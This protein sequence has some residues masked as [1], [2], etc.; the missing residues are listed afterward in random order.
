MG[1]EAVATVMQ[2]WY[3]TP[4]T[5]APLAYWGKPGKLYAFRQTAAFAKT[6]AVHAL[7]GAGMGNFS[8]K[9]ATKATGLG[10]EGHFPD[11]KIYVSKNYMQAH[12]FT[13]LYYFAQP[14]EA[15]SMMNMPNSV[16]NQLA[17]EYGITGLLLFAFLY[18]GFFIRH[19]RSIKA[20]RYMLLAVLLFF[21]YEY[22]FE[23]IS[24][25]V[26]FELLSLTD[27][28]SNSVHEGNATSARHGIDAGL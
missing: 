19:R 21:G 15:H 27:I 1:R 7:L 25:T 20:T 5:A 2:T 14:A 17:G 26:I 6:S 11:S 3:H 9:L 16:Y 13:T 28:F 10:I 12:L 22:W 18:L 23:M 4:V 8:S 24:L